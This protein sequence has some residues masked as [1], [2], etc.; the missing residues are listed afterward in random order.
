MDDG[1]GMTMEEAKNCVHTKQNNEQKT[2][3]LL[4]LLLLE[5]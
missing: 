1:G 4:L 2:T 5:E 3:F